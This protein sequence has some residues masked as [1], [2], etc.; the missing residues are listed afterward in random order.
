M[1]NPFVEL[2]VGG[3]VPGMVGAT[4]DPPGSG[5]VGGVV[6]TAATAVGSFVIVTVTVEPEAT[7][8]TTGSVLGGLPST[9]YVMTQPGGNA[10]LSSPTAQRA[11]AATLRRLEKQHER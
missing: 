8:K 10:A 7:L 2:P 4:V 6:V 11:L 1:S 3:S 5:V 9:E